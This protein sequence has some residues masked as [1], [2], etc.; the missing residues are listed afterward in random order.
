MKLSIVALK[1]P[2]RTL[3]NRPETVTST[4]AASEGYDLDLSQGMVTVSREGVDRVRLIPVS[5]VAWMEAAKGA[6]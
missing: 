2:A 6:K 1:V 5:A 4:Y 3:D